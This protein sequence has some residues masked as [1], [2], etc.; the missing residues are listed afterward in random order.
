MEVQF[1]VIG[2]WLTSKNSLTFRL[3]LRRNYILLLNGM[4]TI[5]NLIK[6]TVLLVFLT[7]GICVKSYTQEEPEVF[8]PTL[9]WSGFT[10]IWTGYVQRDSLDVHYGFSVRYFRWKASG[11]L[12]PNVKWVTQIGLDRGNPALLDVFLSYEP[13][14]YLNVRFGQF[15]VPGAKSGV[16]SSSIWSTASMVLNDRATITQNW[17][18]NAGLSGFRSGGIMAYGGFLDKKVNYYVMAAMPHAGPAFYWNPSVK[19][20]K[21]EN[22]ENGI[23][24][25][26]RLEV[27]PINKMEV[28]VNFHTGQGTSLDSIQINRLS[29]GFYL[30]TRQEKLYVMAE[31]IGGGNE[32][33]INDVKSSDFN[34]NGYFIEAAYKVTE[35]LE[36]VVRYDSYTPDDENPD[37]NGYNRYNNLTIGVNYYPAKNIAIMFNYVARMEDAAP[38]FEEIDNALFYFQLRYKFSSK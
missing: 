38:G 17:N 29:Y 1:I 4:S 26:S 11:K 22:D 36:P 6:I 27:V 19:S 34:Y 7:G 20:P 10:H 14:E 37:A 21:Y 2:C 32:Q 5:K 28:G 24:L 25:F 18:S 15:P 16:L 12:T 13:V 31:Y 33:L 9:K 30:L 35:Q 23:A 3:K 8:K